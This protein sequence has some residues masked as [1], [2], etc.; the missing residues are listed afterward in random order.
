[1]P[2]GPDAHQADLDLGIQ[3]LL[4]PMVDT[5]GQAAEIVRSTRYPPDGVR[6]MAGARASRWGRY[7][8]YAHEANGTVCLLLQVETTLA[9]DNLDAIACT[10][11]VDGVFI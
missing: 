6:G 4:V 10:D 2:R 7:P 3:T 11:G 5:P 8:R 1:M 9:L